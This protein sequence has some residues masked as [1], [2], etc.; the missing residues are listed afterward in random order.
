[1]AQNSCMMLVM[2]RTC[3]LQLQGISKSFPGVKALQDVSVDLFPGEVHAL[4]GENGAGKSTLIKILGGLYRADTGRVSLQGREVHI[5][6]PHQAQLLGISVIYQE[7]NLL[8]DLTVAENVFAGR[9]P[10]RAGVLDWRRMARDAEQ[11]FRELGVALDPMAPVRSLSVAEKQLVEIAKAMSLDARVIVMDEPTAALSEHE[12]EKLLALVHHLKERNKGIL[13]VSHRL[14]E[15][16][17]VADRITVLR[18]GQRVDTRNK[19]ETDR[20][21]VVRLM[22]GREMEDLFRKDSSPR[23]DVRLSVRDLC[24]GEALRGI[25]FELKEG[26]I[27]GVFGL[28]GSGQTVLAEALYGVRSTASGQIVLDGQPVRL[29]GEGDAISHRVGFLSED[30]KTAGIMPQ[31]SVVHNLTLS[32]LDRFSRWKGLV[33]K[34]KREREY[35]EGERD[36][37]DIRCRS[38]RQEIQL[39]SGG[40]QQKVLLGRALAGECRVLI[41]CEPTRGV[42]VGAKAEIHALMNDLAK[43]GVSILLISSDLP[44]VMSMSDACLVIREGR[45]EGRLDKSEMTETRVGRLATGEESSRKEKTAASS[46]R[47][48]NTARVEESRGWALW[49][50]FGLAFIILGAALALSFANPSF[51]TWN[52]A[53]NFVNQATIV[54]ITGAGMTLAIAS[55]G[56]D[57]SVGSTLALASCVGARVLNEA[58]LPVS[59]AASLAAGTVIGAANGLIIAKLRV[60]P[61]IATLGMMAILRG[62]VLLFTNGRDI[63]IVPQ[64]M[65]AY[66]FLGGG[67]LLGVPVPILLMGFVFLGL[68]GI[69]W[70]TRF[71]RHLCAVGSNEDAAACSGLAV[72]RIRVAVFLVVGLCAAIS[73]MVQTAQIKGVSGASAGLGFE[74]Q[75]ISVAILGGT[76]LQGG[77]GKLWGTMMA[78]VLVAM[79]NNAL[80]LY[81]TPSF[82]QSLVMGLILLSAVSL[83]GLRRKSAVREG[84]T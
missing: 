25:S 69:L 75:A 38:H 84:R 27:L 44:E 40:N 34:R 12:T 4:V 61:L 2:S 51:R 24:V 10:T 80:N 56:F 46:L 18:D 83:D 49:D 26:E 45:I 37:L 35:F 79:A 76:S 81:N 15:V 14:E 19:E 7:F 5:R 78:A 3:S 73:G 60:P 21:E 9:E 29:Q 47:S 31:M 54:A 8:P 13:F 32:V 58:G 74:L 77:R 16:F 11:L 70:Y 17:A 63:N 30:R 59:V 48:K 65:D 52:N 39:L 22:V 64:K 57:L 67:R 72:D 6:S 71:G 55:G 41:L 42:D 20:A 28:M 1:L 50:R 33:L 66:G 36:R 23:E 43:E 68:Y 53:F 62:I 82:Y